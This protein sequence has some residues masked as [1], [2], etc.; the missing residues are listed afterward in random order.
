[1]VN[2][3]Q[4]KAFLVLFII[5]SVLWLNFLGCAP[6][7]KENI[8]I[9]D[10]TMTQE[11]VFVPKEKILKPEK[12]N[13][14][15]LGENFSKIEDSRQTKYFA[16]ENEEFKKVIQLSQAF[17]KQDELIESYLDLINLHIGVNNYL[18][19]IIYGKNMMLQHYSDLYVNEQNLRLQ[20]NY[21]N[22]QGKIIDRAIIII[23]T[24]VIL[25]LA[26]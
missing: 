9:P 18:K 7:I 19:D 23:Q 22:K 17:D 16:F 4:A 21:L 24:I 20:E 10:I 26:L 3:R 25:A 14:I 13:P 5:C 15:I 11:E 12:P 2:D 8:L 1:M 6:A